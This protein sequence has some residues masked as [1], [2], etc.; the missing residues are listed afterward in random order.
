MRE[1]FKV[2]AAEIELPAVA[3]KFPLE[4]PLPGSVVKARAEISFT[5]H[6]PDLKK[7]AVFR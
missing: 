4:A 2:M 1:L 6:E 3:T 7:V 5:V